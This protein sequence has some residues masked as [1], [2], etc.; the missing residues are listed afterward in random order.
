[1]VKQRKFRKIRAYRS[2]NGYY[3]RTERRDAAIEKAVRAAVDEFFKSRGL[4][5]GLSALLGGVATP[6]MYG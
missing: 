1:M 3:A 5:A 4:G 2:F 6:F